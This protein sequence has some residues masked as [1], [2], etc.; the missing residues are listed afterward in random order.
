MANPKLF[1]PASTRKKLTIQ[2]LDDPGSNLMDLGAE[3][4]TGMNQE[5]RFAFLETL[6]A[7]YHR[8]VDE[9][10]QLAN[11]CVDRYD[12][13][14]SHHNSWRRRIIVGTG[15]VAIINLLA[16][17]HSLSQWS[18]NILPISAAIAALGLT[19]LAN[20]ESFYNF[21]DRAQAYRESR[22]LFLDAAREFQRVWDVYVQPFGSEPH[23]CANGVELYRRVVSND[24]E[25]RSKFKE[26]TKTKD[27][28]KGT[29][30]HGK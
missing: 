29:G 28:G 17:N 15:I 13:A 22:E 6:D 23:A 2:V 18:N 9:F 10:Y 4:W 20:L 11:D 25:L 27:G 21:A 26:L 7:N 14:S 30:S 16:A 8:Y 12:S 5:E 19:V 1:G 3:T 24:R